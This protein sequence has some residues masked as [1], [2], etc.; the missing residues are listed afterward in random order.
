M[1]FHLLIF[2]WS[3]VC[4]FFEWTSSGPW[5]RSPL[6][7]LISFPTG[8]GYCTSCVGVLLNCL[9]KALTIWSV[10][11]PMSTPL[12]Y[13]HLVSLVICLKEGLLTPRSFLA[14]Q[15][16]QLKSSYSIQ[17]SRKCKSPRAKSLL[18]GMPGQGAF[19]FVRLDFAAPSVIL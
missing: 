7:W 10:A 1:L 4:D 8:H 6:S 13:M 17:V 15:V 16:Y 19:P 11:C 5:S 14:W 12:A 9:Q 3:W 2:Q 18:F